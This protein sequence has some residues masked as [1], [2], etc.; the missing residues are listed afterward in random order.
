MSVSLLIRPARA[1]TYGATLLRVSSEVVRPSW[2]AV[3]AGNVS[4]RNDFSSNRLFGS[5]REVTR[6]APLRDEPGLIAYE[7]PACSYVTSLFVSPAEHIMA[8]KL[9]PTG[10]GGGVDKDPPDFIVCSGKWDVGRIYQ[11]RG[12]P[13]N[14]R[15]FWSMNV[16]G[17]MARADRVATLEEAKA[18][19]QKCW[20]AWKAWAKLVEAD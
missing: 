18:G 13:D 9:R 2:L 5:V 17:P 7:C 12:G 15:W 4:G 6:I 10:L 20:E 8:L 11:A 16:N 14:L 19:V 3:G 1:Q